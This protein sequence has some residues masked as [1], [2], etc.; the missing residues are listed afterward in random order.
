MEE[1]IAGVTRSIMNDLEFNNEPFST[2]VFLK[3]ANHYYIDTR[4]NIEFAKD[5]GRA[6]IRLVAIKH[7]IDTMNH[8]PK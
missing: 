2:E 1:I 4:R 5:P 7:L 3:Y 6:M 8:N